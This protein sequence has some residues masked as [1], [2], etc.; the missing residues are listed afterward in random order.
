M[1]RSDF[2]IHALAAAAAVAMTVV[3]DVDP[4]EYYLPDE[5]KKTKFDRT[6]RSDGFWSN[7]RTFV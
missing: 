2:E 5:M 4:A 1:T 6:R 7:S 3:G